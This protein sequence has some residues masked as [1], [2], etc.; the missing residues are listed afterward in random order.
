M[1]HF[2]LCIDIAQHSK[3]VA[4]QISS[5]LGTTCPLQLPF[6]ERRQMP[7]DGQRLFS[8][9]DSAELWLEVG[10]VGQGSVETL[11]EQGFVQAGMHA[12]RLAR[13]TD[14]QGKVPNVLLDNRRVD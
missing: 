4:Q 12:R 6:D 8:V 10:A 3:D 9:V 2:L 5:R 7:C 14:V 11:R 13:K 1:Q